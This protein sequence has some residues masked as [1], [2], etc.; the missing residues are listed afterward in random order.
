MSEQIKNE[1]KISPSPGK[2]RPTQLITTYG[3]GAFVQ[4]EN[5][6]VMVMAIDFWHHRDE[7]IQKNHVYIQKITKKDHFRMPYVDET[8]SR[9]IACIS[10]PRWGYCSNSK[11]QLL[12]F[13]KDAPRSE[14]GFFCKHHPSSSLLPARLVT[15]CNRGHVDDFPWIEWAHSNHK[16]PRP[17]CDEPKI[18]WTGGRQTSSISN[19]KLKCQCGAENSMSKTTS[20]EG[21]ELYDEEKAKK[22][23]HPFT[24]Y[25]CTGELPWLERKETCKKIGSDKNDECSTEIPIGIIVRSTSLYYSKIIRGI[26]IPELAHPII[27]YLQSTEYKI[28]KSSPMFNRATDE[29]KAEDILESKKDWKEV[30]KYTIKQIV[31]FMS[32]LT[33]REGESSE[34]NTELDLKKIEYDDL[35]HNENFED[36]QIEKEIEIQNVKL[37]DAEK[38]YFKIVRRLDILTALEIPRYFTRL[39]PPGEINVKD[40]KFQNETICSIEVAGK[41]KSGRKYEKNNWL[42]CVIK[43]GEGIFLIFNED[44]IKK[45]MN[46]NVKKRLDAI[47]ENHQSWEK[48]T[49][50][51]STLNIDRQYIF[52][53]SLSHLLIKEL[54]LRS[55]YSEASISERIYSS[56]NMV[57]ILIYTTSSGDGSLGGLVR[58][59]EDNLLSILQNALEKAR[60]CSRDPICINED[61][62]K[63]GVKLPLHL[64]QNGSA[65]YGCMMLPETSCEYFNKMLDRRVLVD[66][67]YG[68]VNVIKND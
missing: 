60:V 68:L 38:K 11:C 54:A 3:P 6:S 64:A 33:D 25:C 59:A 34:I 53:H 5:D 31:D 26:I 65:C 32:K 35:I 14:N 52:L 28:H 19:F 62:K 22:G 51:P 10:F 47:V 61:P 49:Q 30:K 9:S 67:D 13:H 48:L 63:M 66:K 18:K 21:I 42:P 45:C 8:S 23:E 36:E 17:I 43:K 46:E 39:K 27:K 2:V 41:T 44:F 16:N 37:D 56:E 1:S 40:K 55:G 50:W 4:T 15:V 20:H 7:Y 58:Q 12:Q 29:E 24:T 57:G